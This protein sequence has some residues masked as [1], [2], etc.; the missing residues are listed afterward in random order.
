[1]LSSGCARDWALLFAGLHQGAV[2]SPAVSVRVLDWTAANT[3]LSMVAAAFAL[4]PLAHTEP[5]LGLRLWNKTG[6]DAGVRADVGLVSRG[7]TAAAYA[8]LAGWDEARG[9]TARRHVL[10]RMRA[11]GEAILAH[12]EQV[13]A[14]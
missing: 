12:L 3:D 9:P 8:V 2:V 10:D 13:T 6:S 1:M 7:D 14:D 11:T 5:D 4:D